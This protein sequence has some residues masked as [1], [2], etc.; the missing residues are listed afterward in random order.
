MSR[1][2][3]NPLL[4]ELHLDEWGKGGIEVGK[5]DKIYRDMSSTHRRFG[6]GEKERESPRV[7]FGA[8][9]SLLLFQVHRK[10]RFAKAGE[11]GASQSLYEWCWESRAGAQLL[12]CPWPWAPLPK[13]R[14]STWVAQQPLTSIHGTWPLRWMP[15]LPTVCMGQWG[16]G[17]EA[18]TSAMA[19]WQCMQGESKVQL[20]DMK[21]PPT[22]VPYYCW[23][24]SWAREKWHP[25]QG[26]DRSN[27]K[28]HVW[29]SSGRQK[30]DWRQLMWYININHQA[31]AHS[32]SPRPTHNS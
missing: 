25:S 13:Q 21:G 3:E 12:C 27:G 18:A 23:L 31:R 30:Q 1:C 8:L 15:L 26:R 6:G 17:V 7:W 28:C 32:L 20:P 10:V 19:A 11:E 4:S 22:G 5:A 24:G 16:A 9:T 2:T 29:F 14:P